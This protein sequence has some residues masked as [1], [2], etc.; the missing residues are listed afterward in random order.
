MPN[1]YPCDGIFN[2]HLTTIKDFYNPIFWYK[3]SLVK[4]WYSRILASVCLAIDDGGEY[5]A[6]ISG[7]Y[8]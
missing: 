8:S 4:I 7:L 1:S 6:F 5:E 3:T 2:P